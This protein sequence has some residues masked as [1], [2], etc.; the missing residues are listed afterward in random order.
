MHDRMV[1]VLVAGS[2]VACACVSTCVCF[3]GKLERDVN[4]NA[5]GCDLK[6]ILF[7]DKVANKIDS[8]K[9]LLIYLKQ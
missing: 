1:I 3:K 6:V 8:L 5:A 7:G 4:T 9:C 2:G